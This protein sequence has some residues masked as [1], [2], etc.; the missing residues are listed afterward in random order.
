M[1]ALQAVRSHPSWPLATPL[2]VAV[3]LHVFFGDNRRRDIDNVTKCVD[4]FNGVVWKDDS[5]IHELHIFR[6][7]DR[8]RPR[9]EVQVEILAIAVELKRNSA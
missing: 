3:S 4:A 2:P 9:V 8:E 1:L 5:Q 7:L 6:H